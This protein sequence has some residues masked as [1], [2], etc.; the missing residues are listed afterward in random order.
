MNQLSFLDG[1]REELRLSLADLKLFVKFL[2]EHQGRCFQINE[3]QYFPQ[4]SVCP[5]E[6]ELS[7]HAIVI[8]DKRDSPL[9][10]ESRACEAR[11]RN[12]RSNSK[13][14]VLISPGFIKMNLTLD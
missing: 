10:S 5:D 4:C 9:R 2:I 11:V 8:E 3:R 7:K 13:I 14:S 1:P 12:T 6:I